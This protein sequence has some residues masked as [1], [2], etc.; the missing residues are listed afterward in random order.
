MKLAP[1]AWLAALALF[2]SCVTSPS[3]T[4]ATPAPPPK[5]AQE[6]AGECAAAPSHRDFAKAQTAAAQA[7]QL[8]P[9]FEEAWVGFGMASVRLGQSDLAR[10]AYGRALELHQTRRLQAPPDAGQV[11]QEIFLLSLLGRSAEAD[12]LLKRAR[13]EFP[14][15]PQIITLSGNFAQIKQTWEL[16]TV[17]SP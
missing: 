2:T 3:G 16:W 6:L 7:T 1:I 5:T 14:N 4:P 15:D 10:A 12:A 11:Y 9:Q 17:K 13:A 8:N